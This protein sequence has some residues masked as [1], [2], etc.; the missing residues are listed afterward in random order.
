MSNIYAIRNFRV[1]EN[2]IR[3]E[4]DD[5]TIC[6]PFER[7]GSK[8]LLFARS[9][10]RQVFEVDDD[11]LGV[12]WPLLDEDLSIAGLLRAAGRDDLVVSAIPSSYREDV[13]AVA[14][15]TVSY[16]RKTPDRN[17]VAPAMCPD[18]SRDCI[19]ARIHFSEMKKCAI[20]QH[21]RGTKHECTCAISYQ[22][23]R[24]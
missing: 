18:R 16:P 1:T 6:V 11:G 22:R 21:K 23:T 12:H 4:L 24:K 19:P 20:L 7:S 13:P 2:A 9:E 17:I 3:F 14:P 5:A 15:S 10:Q 8:L